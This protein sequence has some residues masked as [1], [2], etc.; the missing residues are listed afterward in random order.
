S[1]RRAGQAADAT[2]RARGGR[3]RPGDSRR[4]RRHPRVGAGDNGGH[5][6]PA[7]GRHDARIGRSDVSRPVRRRARHRRRCVAAERGHDRCGTNF[8]TLFVLV[9]GFVDA[10][11]PRTPLWAGAIWRVLLVPL[12]AAIAYEVMRLAA[13]EH[14][15]VWSRVVTWPG[16]AA[17]RLTTREPT[18]A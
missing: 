5:P 1:A 6:R 18:D 2:V 14:G 13:R 16:R 4:A 10:L 11:V 7:P 9:A 3:S 8:A 17:Q 15:E 12:V